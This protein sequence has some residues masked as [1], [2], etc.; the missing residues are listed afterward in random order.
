MEKL[1]IVD[2]SSMLVTCYYATLPK[3]VMFAKTE[4]EKIESYKKILQT[5]DGVYTNAVFGMLRIIKKILEYQKPEYICFCFD[6]SRNTFRRDM[7]KE[8]KAQRSKTPSPLS[9]QFVLMEKILE[10][11]GFKVL[12]DKQYE[13]DDLAGSVAKKFETEVKTFLMTKDHDYL[14]LANDY[15]RIWMVQTS[16]EKAEALYSQFYYPSGHTRR[17]LNLPPRVFEYTKTHVKTLEG[18][19]PDQIPDLKGIMGDASDNIPGVKGVSS[20]AAPLLSEY[21]TVE[22]L[23]DTIESCNEKELKELV[24]FWKESLGI[25]RSPLNALTK[26]SETEL[27]GKEAALLS[28]SLATIKTDIPITFGLEDM[29][30]TYDESILKDILKQLEIK[31]L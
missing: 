12:Y 1:L 30:A 13:A 21:G 2:G 20:A 22:N 16:D 7:Y 26:E 19:W 18:V 23:Y 24:K 9:S 31:T 10:S 8:Y 29:S 14:Q 5:S 6:M 27:V 4:E 28:K 25:K 11:L 17:T 3:E 15:T